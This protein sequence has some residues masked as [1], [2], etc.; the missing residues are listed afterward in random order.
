MSRSGVHVP[1]GSIT[2]QQTPVEN[3]VAQ[4]RKL[5]PH[6][7]AVS[8]PLSQATTAKDGKTA[9]ATVN[10]DVNPVSLG[11][12]Y[13]TQVD[14]ATAV[15]RSAGVAVS[16][17]SGSASSWTRASSGCLSSLPPWS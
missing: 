12:D 13:V 11:T 17:A 1:S 2:A 5:L 7:L 16:S 14:N 9:Y 10:F 15:A 6:V 8:D 3:A 4:V